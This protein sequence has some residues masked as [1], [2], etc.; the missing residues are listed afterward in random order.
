VYVGDLDISVTR[1][2]LIEHFLKHFDNV[3]G[4]NIIHDNI[5]KLS[6]GYGFVQLATEEDCL[7]AMDV[8]TGTMLKGK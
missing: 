8:L 5:T 6:K 2:I 3:I 7:K 1:E 4:A